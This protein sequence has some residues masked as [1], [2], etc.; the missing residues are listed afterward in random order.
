MITQKV[1]VIL[2]NPV[3]S[4][5]IVPSVQAANAAKIPIIA[6]DRG[7]NGGVL[8]TT[9]A[10]DSIAGGKV[11]ADFLTQMVVSG[12]VVEIQGLPGTSA[13]RDRG[14]GFDTEIGR[15]HV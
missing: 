1:D 2:V 10:S 12:P 15:A 3:D 4:D 13:A 6:L 7:S 14:T 8:A 5:A 9:I 11:A